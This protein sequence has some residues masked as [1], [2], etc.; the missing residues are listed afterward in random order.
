MNTERFLQWMCDEFRPVLT[1]PREQGGVG[2]VK[3]DC[4]RTAKMA[5]AL[6]RRFHVPARELSVRLLIANR[7]LSAWL[8]QQGKS[9]D[10]VGYEGI[11]QVPG[12]FVVM[13]GRRG[14]STFVGNSW[15]GH[16]PVIVED[17]YILD[18]TL[19]GVNDHKVDIEL[20]PFVLPVGVEGIKEIESGSMFVVKVVTGEHLTYQLDAVNQDYKK[21][22][23]WTVWSEMHEGIIN[24]AERRAKEVLRDEGILLSD[25]GAGNG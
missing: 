9:L 4:I 13:M 14:D 23:A 16:L 17:K 3:Q 21:T 11:K 24:A 5:I 7:P 6:C 12:A 25:S 1:K 18:L 20:R 15:R 10:E 2:W 19:D 22:T 8:D